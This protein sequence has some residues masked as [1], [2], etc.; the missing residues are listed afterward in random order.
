MMTETSEID[1]IK[2]SARKYYDLGL[3]VVP[4]KGKTPLLEWKPLQTNRQTSRDFENLPW[5]KADGFALIGGS[6]RSDGLY[7]CA[8]DLDVKNVPTEAF[9]KG[10]MIANE[11]PR[12][13]TER[14]PSGG[15]HLIYLSREKPRTISVFH[16]LAA[17]EL[18]GENKLIIMAPS[19]G[20]ENVNSTNDCSKS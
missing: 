5:S 18:L 9:K 4:V 1:R 20:Y 12:T 14:T 13:Q 16:Q 19:R 2:D 11:L 17:L 7:I 3:N 8:I 10:Q 15:L 6:Q